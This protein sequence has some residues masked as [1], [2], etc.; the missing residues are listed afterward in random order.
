MN[1]IPSKAN[2]AF[3]KVPHSI[4]FSE[5]L[6]P[7]QKMVWIMLDATCYNRETEVISAA[8]LAKKWGLPVRGLQRT[9]QELVSMGFITKDG[10]DYSLEVEPQEG[11]ESTGVRKERR[12]TRD[13]KLRIELKEI[14][15]KYKPKNAPSMQDFTPARL[16]TLRVYAERFKVDEQVVLRKVCDG[17]NADE[18]RRDK[19][20]S[21]DNIF[22]SGVPSEDKQ[23]KVEKVYKLGCT[24]K[25][26]NAV[27]DVNDD[28][29]WLDWFHSKH[30]PGYTQVDR[31]K[32]VD[33]EEAFLHNLD[34]PPAPDTIRVYQ[35]ETGFP[36]FWT[37]DSDPRFV[38]HQ[39]PSR[40]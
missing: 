39:L 8:K 14:W 25:A 30:E 28:Q 1:I 31:C 33:R 27:F 19:D 7:H 10:D 26:A 24:K 35:T 40:A 32:A 17:S 29:C 20:W 37:K 12:L 3:S 11:A 23:T 5:I 38:A 36:C 6:T 13:E 2:T 34:N 21:F 15:N 4:T 16:K 22:G 9:I 18:W